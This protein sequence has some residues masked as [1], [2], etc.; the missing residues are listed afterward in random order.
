MYF[1]NE[2]PRPQLRRDD[3]V[4]LNGKWQFCFDEEITDKT[5]VTS[6]QTELSQT[7]NVPFSYQY[8]ASGIGVTDYYAG[9]WYKR[10]FTL[11]KAQT[12]R[13]ALLC[14]NAVDYECSVWLNGV[15][16]GG[17]K[18]GFTPFTLDVTAQ[19]Q[20]QNTLVVYCRDTMDDTVARGKQSWRDNGKP[21]GCWYTPNSGIWQSVWIEFFDG[22][23]VDYV[24]F[25][26][27][28]ATGNVET[29]L[30]TGL[31]V[32]TEVQ[33]D[34]TFGGKR[35]GGG[36]FMLDGVHN[37]FTFEA[38]DAEFAN[39]HLWDVDEPS[40]FDVDVTLLAQ[41]KAVDVTHTYFGFRT[42]VVDEHG[43]VLLNG[44][45]LYQRLILDQGYFAEGGLTAESEE[46][47]KRDIELS[48]AMGYNGARKH[49]KLEDP[50]FYYYADRMGYLVWCEMPS[51]YRFESDE[52]LNI[53]NEWQHIVRTVVNNPSVICFVPLNES[54]GVEQIVN[55]KAQQRFA[56]AMYYLTKALDGTRLVST[57]D[58]WEYVDDTDIVGIHDYSFSGDGFAEKYRRDALDDIVPAGK[59]LFANGHKYHGQPVM[60]SEF[61]GIAMQRDATA[62]ED[63]GYNSKAQNDD[64][65]YT[66]YANLMTNLHKMWFS[67]FCYTQLTDVQQEINGLLDQHHNPK[68]DIAT[69]RKLTTGQKD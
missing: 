63:W 59:R 52:Q 37:K 3:W 6:G 35:V 28:P 39:S 61:G 64:E 26:P 56:S 7:I 15:Y 46:M 69:I 23:Y 22:D 16:V 24:G 2:Y 68:F 1:R 4:A 54:W 66:R 9:M 34:V 25:K 53:A 32:A 13:S 10:N 38:C 21:F 47:F 41:G 33:I 30:D 42:V 50:Y 57:N 45:P 29:E 43:A 51:A 60:F 18:G 20:E 36:K 11:G 19:M 14:F 62:S 67:G 5:A 44:K 55:D 8:A 48:I 58:G 31:G 27:D 17:H 40:L 12:S 49:Q 65:F